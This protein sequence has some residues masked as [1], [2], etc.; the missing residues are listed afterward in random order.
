VDH[1]SY[2]VVSM[3]VNLVANVVV[4]DEFKDIVKVKAEK[5]GDW[6]TRNPESAPEK[7]R[8][9][10][11]KIIFV[12]GGP[13][14]GEI[15][16]LLLNSFTETWSLSGKGTQCE[17]IVK[18]YGY[19][20]LSS[21]DLLREEVKSNSPLAQ[22]INK[23]MEKGALVPNKLILNMIKNAMDAK[24]STSNGFLIDGYPRQVE[25]GIEFEKEVHKHTQFYLLSF[26][27]CFKIGTCELVLHI[28]ASEDTMVKRLLKRGE[29][30]G[31][32]DD[33][34]ETIRARLKIFSEHTKP[35]IDHY[36]HQGKVHH[37][38]SEIAPEE[39]FQE[40]EKILDKLN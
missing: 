22:E 37:I 14:S 36:T 34:E 31:R 11:Q 24:M 25:Q 23:Y 8:S 29:T 16:R 15:E 6:R 13:G 19:T 18:K 9:Q 28:D 20:H 27:L 30:S 4:S 26:L 1:D 12:I 10:K 35:V 40:V 21:G 39:V 2:S 32:V 33:N 5:T 3:C 7:H 17:R 38:N